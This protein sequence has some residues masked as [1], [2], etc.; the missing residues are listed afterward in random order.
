MNEMTVNFN[1]QDYI[2]IYNKDSGY[3]EIDITAPETGGIYNA[4]IKYTDLL[5]EN[6]E[7]S[8]AI[9]VLAKEKIK[10]ETN[11]IFMWI[12]DYK[13]FSVKDIVEI[14]D[15]EINIDE[16]TNTNSLIKVLKKTT[17]KAKDIVAIKKNNEVV[18]WGKIENIA[19]ENGKLLYEYT[20]KYITNIFNQNIELKRLDEIKNSIYVEDGLYVVRVASNV[21][22]VVNV[23]IDNTENNALVI[24][25]DY[26]ASANQFLD[27]IKQQDNYYKIKIAHSEK[28]LT[29]KTSDNN[30]VVQYENI[31][32]DSQLWKIE[33]SGTNKYSFVS[34]ASGLY[35]R[36]RYS[37]NTLRADGSEANS[38]LS[39]FRM[40]WQKDEDT[41]R[42]LGVED[43][44]RRAIICNF[45]ESEDELINKKYIKIVTKTHTPKQISVTNV[46]DNIYNLHTWMTN[47]TQLYNI[48]YNISVNNKK[49]IIEIENKTAKKELIDVKAQAISK[50]FEVFSTNI[51]SKVKVLTTTDTYYLYL[52]NNRTTTTDMLNPN[53]A[54][55]ETE[56]VYIENYEEAPQKAL[57]TIK[58]NTYNHNITFDIYN[59]MM[60]IGTPIAIKTKESII[61]DTYISAI[62]ITPQKFITYTCGNIRINL[63]D[64][65]L[66]ERK[67]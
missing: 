55:G 43:F 20:L 7:E 13:D 12:F 61:Y 16:E 38:E 51:V 33:K 53:R 49:L 8:K 25:S 59:K 48:N 3:Y 39:Q 24:A 9:Q 64:K 63:I 18:Y 52:L 34:K 46:Q 36:V 50:Y 42:F 23:N 32:N 54:E 44:I 60:K 37:N 11:K 62:K 14:A 22:K 6:Y 27:I 41:M 56:T 2:A 29:V 17:A 45:V 26:T 10:I 57:D 30:D 28:F 15:Y 35:L 19:N 67:K 4:N 1:G 65:L 31:D 66:K 47:C 21:D 5:E 40:D 58:S